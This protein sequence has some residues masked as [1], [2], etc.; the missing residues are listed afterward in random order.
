MIVKRKGQRLLFAAAAMLAVFALAG[1]AY[2]DPTATIGA[3]S[4]N[5]NASES[6]DPIDVAGGN[7]DTSV[8]I[9]TGSGKGNAAQAGAASGN[10]SGSVAVG[11]VNADAVSGAT[12]AGGQVGSCGASSAASGGAASA[13][14]ESDGAPV[15]G[16]PS[17]ADE[18]RGSA[19]VGCIRAGGSS[20]STAA[21]G[22]VG[23][24]R[25]GR[26]GAGGSAGS[27][28]TTAGAGV[29]CIVASA[30]GE[31]NG[32][33][34]VGRCPQTQGESPG[35]PPAPGPG[36]LDEGGGLG[37]GLPGPDGGVPG[38]DV[39]GANTSDEGGILAAVRSGQLPLT[40]LP[41]L[42]VLLASVAALVLAI[43]MYRRRARQPSHA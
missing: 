8:G 2:A 11:C 30:T 19:H 24:C 36:G 15:A 13:T 41:L 25:G 5:T 1:N 42:P 4:G 17:V 20:G 37:G 32:A 3:Q 22:L 14:V 27:G 12:S 18:T 31:A 33:V 23:S 6:V 10:S 40:G 9:S 26:G 21:S 35:E 39:I 43:A 29:G 38:S 7:G 34:R 28:D 16:G